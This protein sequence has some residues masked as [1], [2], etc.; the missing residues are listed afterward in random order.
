MAY[1]ELQSFKYGLDT[2]RSELTSQPGTLETLNNA[3]I[4]QGGEIE[5]RKALVKMGLGATTFPAQ[6]FGLQPIQ[7]AVLVFGSREVSWTITSVQGFGTSVL[8]TI[9]P[10]ISGL[11]PVIG[12]SIVV[13]GTTNFNGTFIVGNVIGSV[14]Q[15]A[16]VNS[17]AQETVGTLAFNFVTPFVYQQLLHPDGVTQMNGV[18]DSKAFGN[19]AWVIATFTDGNTFEFY[20]GVEIQDFF[21]GLLWADVTNGY[22]LLQDFVREI[23]NTGVYTAILDPLPIYLSFTVAG[24]QS[25]TVAIA[26]SGTF[27]FSVNAPP[28]GST[29]TIGGQTYTFVVF[30]DNAVANQIVGTNTSTTNA[31]TNLVAAVN[32]APGGGTLYSTPTVANPDVGA[33]SYNS[34]LRQLLVTATVAGAAGNAF[35]IS[36]TYG[37]ATTP[38]LTGGVDATAGTGFITFGSY[39]FPAVTQLTAFLSTSSPTIIQSPI[40]FSGGV[41]TLAQVAT[42]VAAAITAATD[43][44]A[45][46]PGDNLGFVAVAVG[47]QVN[48]YPPVNLRPADS[49]T[50]VTDNALTV[51][52]PPPSFSMEVFSIPSV[53][54]GTPYTITTTVTSL[55]GVLSSR[56]DNTGIAAVPASSAVGQFALIKGNSNTAATGT[57][58]N[59]SNTNLLNGDLVTI[60]N[61]IYKAVSVFS[62]AINEFQIQGSADATMNALIAAI[63]GGLGAGTLYATGTV[64]NTQVSAGTLTAHAF[65]VTSLIG[66]NVGNSIQTTTTSVYLA[67]GGTTLSGG[68]ASDTNQI[69]QVSVGG[70]NL[71]SSHV[72][73]NKSVNQT[74]LDLANAINATSSSTNY[75]ASSNTNIITITSAIT[76]AAFNGKAVIVTCGG[77]VCTDNLF[78][79]FTSFV[80]STSQVRLIATSVTNAAGSVTT[81]ADIMNGTT[82][83]YGTPVTVANTLTF[84]NAIVSAINAFTGTSGWLAWTDGIALLYLSRSV[85]NSTDQAVSMTSLTYTSLTVTQ[86]VNT[87]VV[88]TLNTSTVS[89]TLVPGGRIGVAV[90]KAVPEPSVIASGGTPPY[91][92]LWAYS[93]I[94]RSVIQCSNTKV[95]NPTFTSRVAPSGVEPW[96]VTVTDANNSSTSAT[97]N[98][99]AARLF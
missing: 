36:A 80:A 28:L 78:I 13:S 34:S 6:T 86:G 76:G 59:G 73:F 85:A 21:N 77:D 40:G 54:D 39:N 12:D 79:S 64:A 92:Y 66:G 44:Y 2:R 57:L 97:V 22:L 30:L 82:V 95:A 17:S 62:G 94:T 7:N 15:W 9:Q 45:G 42:N 96:T 10:G 70:T 41:T 20:N 90:Y 55:N 72:Q 84:F 65:T 5:K 60:G 83:T 35:P 1:F 67:W 38:T 33:T 93:G 32:G 46:G 53:T 49:L 52:T 48:V 87:A 99:F 68:D 24:G 8:A 26:A 37:S 91:T 25:G 75:T 51:T 4:N 31:I 58:T 19:A 3:H 14:L 63:N 81:H 69:T 88:A 29:I 16:Q 47:N 71:L 74:A 61:T 98:F 89:M 56:L 11:L 23:N 43:T 27:N 50:I 18:V